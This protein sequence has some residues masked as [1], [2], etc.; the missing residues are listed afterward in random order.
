MKNLQEKQP[1]EIYVD[2]DEFLKLLELFMILKI[3]QNFNLELEVTSCLHH[4]ILPINTKHTIRYYFHTDPKLGP[5][6]FVEYLKSLDVINGKLK[7]ILD[8]EYIFEFIGK[9]YNKTHSYTV[10]RVKMDVNTLNDML[11][12]IAKYVVYELEKDIYNLI[13]EYKTPF[14]DCEISFSEYNK[15]TSLFELFSDSADYLESEE[16]E[17][18]YNLSKINQCNYFRNIDAVDLRINLTLFSISK[19]INKIN[20]RFYDKW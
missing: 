8:K 7:L 3:E 5:Q 14:W 16:N 1:K 19:E 18:N 20:L 10:T 4:A 2:R 11:R 12:T 6:K 9:Y 13:I 17:N 15:D